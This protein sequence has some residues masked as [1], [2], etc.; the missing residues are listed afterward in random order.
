VLAVERVARRLKW[1]DTPAG[2][3]Q[4]LSNQSFIFFDI[5]IGLMVDFKTF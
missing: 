2:V 4:S 5:L 3:K 1:R